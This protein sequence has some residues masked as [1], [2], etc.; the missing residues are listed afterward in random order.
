[1]R[2]ITIYFWQWNNNTG[3]NTA[4]DINSFCYM[5][6]LAKFNSRETFEL[7]FL[8]KMK[9][10][11]TFWKFSHGNW[12][13]VQLFCWFL[14]IESIERAYLENKLYAFYRWVLQ[15]CNSYGLLLWMCVFVYAILLTSSCFHLK[16]WKYKRSAS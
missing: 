11:G 1:M 9:R 7:G 6:K 4:T 5:A 3:V 15:S 2:N 13:T 16:C 10:L 12:F 14:T 8:A